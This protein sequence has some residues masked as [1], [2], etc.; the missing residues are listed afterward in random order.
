MTQTFVRVERKF[1]QGGMAPACSVGTCNTTG[2]YRWDIFGHCVGRVCGKH[3][4]EMQRV[5]TG[6]LDVREQVAA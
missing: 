1:G 6:A 5:W 4:N 3:R 2:L